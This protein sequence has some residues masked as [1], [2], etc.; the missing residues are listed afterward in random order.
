MPEDDEDFDLLRAIELSK[1]SLEE[2]NMKKKNNIDENT[3]TNNN[4]TINKKENNVDADSSSLKTSINNEESPMHI[5]INPEA[6]PLPTSPTRS[7]SL[8]RHFGVTCDHCNVHPILGKRYKCQMCFDYDLCQNCY[9]NPSILQETHL[10]TNPTHTFQI[11]APRRS[12]LRSFNNSNNVDRDDRLERRLERIRNVGLSSKPR[13][14][15]DGNNNNKNK[16]NTNKKPMTCLQKICCC[17]TCIPKVL[18]V[19]IVVLFKCI[20]YI[21]SMK[22]YT[23]EKCPCLFNLFS[24][25]TWKRLRIYIVAYVLWML[26]IIIF[27]VLLCMY[28]DPKISTFGSLKSKKKLL[29][30]PKNEI[31]SDRGYVFAPLVVF[32]SML[33]IGSLRTFFISYDPQLFP[34]RKIK[35]WFYTCLSVVFCFMLT[36]LA[37]FLSLAFISDDVGM[38]H[39]NGS[40]R[41][42]HVLIGSVIL[43]WLLICII[44][45][46]LCSKEG[47]DNQRRHVGAGI[48]INMSG[49]CIMT[50]LILQ[51][52]L[53]VTKLSGKAR[54]SWGS[55]LTPVWILNAVAI[56]ATFIIL[57]AVCKD[58]DLH[59]PAVTTLYAIVGAWISTFGSLFFT[60]ILFVTYMDQDFY[61]KNNLTPYN[62]I[63][64]FL[65]VWGF[66]AIIVFVEMIQSMIDG[67]KRYVEMCEVRNLKL[68]YIDSRVEKRVLYG[69]DAI[70]SDKINKKM[71]ELADEAKVIININNNNVIASNDDGS[72]KDNEIGDKKTDI[73]HVETGQGKTHGMDSSSSSSSSSNSNNKKMKN[74]NIII[75]TD[76]EGIYIEID[77]HLMNALSKSS[78]ND[79]INAQSVL[80]EELK[81][82]ISIV[83]KYYDVI[84]HERVY[85]DMIDFQKIYASRTSQLVWDRRIASSFGEILKLTGPFRE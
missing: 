73:D 80:L 84:D 28:L 72:K 79:Y 35:I 27:L 15:N 48:L 40:L 82:I 31:T 9:N 47:E 55:A 65:V 12:R 10:N 42:V 77:T 32:G 2:D 58:D 21:G 74:V 83:K 60:E 68:K 66:Y 69:K 51:I 63:A 14:S 1:L 38:E 62:V 5:P 50:M 57:A 49:G 70:D 46:R 67:C 34:T 30:D 18:I 20:C 45:V 44:G 26:P 75:N 78:L 29:N 19:I 6:P 52:G 64:P 3:F 56:C 85:D 37:F 4:T 36:I 25:P 54:Y 53:F 76:N 61:G 41:A 43:L 24:K 39:R 8:E 81:A 16:N 13:N 59:T 22:W 23:K 71:T 17:I 33:V 7:N 11:V